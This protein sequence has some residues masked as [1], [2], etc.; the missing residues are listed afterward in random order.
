Q[1][2]RAAEE[3]TPGDPAQED[4]ECEAEKQED[5]SDGLGIAEITCPDRV[6]QP[7]RQEGH[8]DSGPSVTP[9]RYRHAGDGQRHNTQ[10]VWPNYYLQED[11]YSEG[12]EGWRKVK[13]KRD[14]RDREQSVIDNPE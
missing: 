6:G 4:Q 12:E 5:W 9:I 2:R 7:E 14:P 11:G 8:T 13:D 10:R 1:Q 3:D